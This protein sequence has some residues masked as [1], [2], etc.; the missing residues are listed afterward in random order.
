MFEKELEIMIKAAYEAEKIILEVY[1]RLFSIEIKSDDSPVTEADKRADALIREILHEAF[2]SYSLLTEESV[3]DLSR[4]ENDYVFIVDPVDGTMEFVRHDDDFCTNIALSYKG[5]IVAGLVN[6]PASK[7]MYYA[8]KG[9]GS[10]KMKEGES[11][12]MIHVSDKEDHL[13]VL[14]SKNHFSDSEKEKYKSMEGK[15]EKMIARGAGLKF[16]A[17]AE[18]SAEVGLRLEP[19]TK[20]WD[21]AP[22]VLLVK[23]AGGVFLDGKMKE[24]SFNKK[25][26]LNEFGYIMANKLKNIK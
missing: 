10:F 20:E 26:T 25:N 4:L 13:T 9:H 14:R 18:G 22:G 15:I 12:I 3:D 11:P 8:L 16:C 6:V 7:T 21:I 23:E 1:S 17:V 19:V 2:P 5:E 24:F